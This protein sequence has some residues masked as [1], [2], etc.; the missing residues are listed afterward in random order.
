MGQAIS[1]GGITATVL[2]VVGGLTWLFAPTFGLRACNFFGNC[3]KA[4]PAY[5]NGGNLQDANLQNNAINDVQYIYPYNNMPSSYNF[6][7]YNKTWEDACSRA[8]CTANA[9]NFFLF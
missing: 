2:A 8:N 7:R 1:I 4:A 9:Y 6:K 5:D 3:E